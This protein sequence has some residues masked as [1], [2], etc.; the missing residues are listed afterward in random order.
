MELVKNIG[1]SFNYH[2][3]MKLSRN[4]AVTGEMIAEV[5]LKDDK[6]KNNILMQPFYPGGDR[7]D[8]PYVNF[9][10]DICSVEKEHMCQWNL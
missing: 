1:I 3:V 7:S 9:Y 6:N 10:W 8:N 2:E 4:G 5:A